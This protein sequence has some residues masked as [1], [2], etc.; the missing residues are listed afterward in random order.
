MAK[1]FKEFLLGGNLVA[2]AV[3]LVMALVFAAVVKALIID[4]ITPIIALIFGQPSFETLSFSINS[5]HFLYGDFINNLIT[6]A[7]T[8]LAVFFFVVRP[9]QHFLASA[10]PDRTC[11]ECTSKIPEHAKRCPMCTAQLV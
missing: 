2:A 10:A 3:G 7:T 8:G 11:P 1:D 9:Y 6:F 5:S 4:I